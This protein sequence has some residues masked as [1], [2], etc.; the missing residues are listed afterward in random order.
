MA[1]HNFINLN[2]PMDLH[3][4]P[5]EPVYPDEA[6]AIRAEEESEFEM[7][8]RRDAIARWMWNDYVKIQWVRIREVVGLVFLE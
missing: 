4:P 2:H 8:D 6:D 1:V 7:E 5:V 3:E